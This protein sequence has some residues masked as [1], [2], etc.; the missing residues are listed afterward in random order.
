MKKFYK[1]IGLLTGIVCFFDMSN[2]SYAHYTQENVVQTD[3]EI[4]LQME[5]TIQM[6]EADLEKQ[7]SSVLNELDIAI[8]FLEQEKS[9]SLTEEEADKLQALIDTAQE[10][11]NSYY[12]YSIGITPFGVS[13]PYYTPAVAAVASFFSSSGYLL[14]FELLIHAEENDDSGSTYRP[15]YGDRILRSLVIKQIMKNLQ[16]VSGSA[17]FEKGETI[18]DNDLYYA[19]HAFNYE[20]KYPPRVLTLTDTYDFEKNDRYEGIAGTAVDTMYIA[21]MLGVLVPYTVVIT[22]S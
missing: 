11:R 2:L 21:Q 5:Q 4:K 9:N 20:F 17:S 13:H 1:F 22:V 3:N 6:I 12:L 18:I 16:D 15:V 10:L 14:A 7:N 8:E 19:I